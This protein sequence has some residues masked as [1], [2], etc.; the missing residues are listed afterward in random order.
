MAWRPVDLFDLAGGELCVVRR[1]L[2]VA[3][4]LDTHDKL[5]AVEK[6]KPGCFRIIR[7]KDR[8]EVPGDCSPPRAYVFFVDRLAV[9]LLNESFEEHQGRGVIEMLGVAPAP[10]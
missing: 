3:S 4:F 2:F 8:S 9:L 7:T 10:A 5:V 6:F 1:Q